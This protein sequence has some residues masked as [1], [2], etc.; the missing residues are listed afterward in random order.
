MKKEYDV[1]DQ[2]KNDPYGCDTPR[3]SDIQASSST[4]MTGLIPVQPESRAE[5]ESYNELYPFLPPVK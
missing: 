4:E 3:T 1:P 5:L 2:I